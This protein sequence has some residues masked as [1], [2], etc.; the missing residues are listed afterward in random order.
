VKARILVVEDN[1]ANLQLMEYLLRSF[2]HEV[3]A[4]DN[5]IAGL[6]EAE[7]GGYDLV[8]SDVRMPHLDGYEFARRFKAEPRLHA[9]PLVA[10]TALAMA[11]D[12]RKA[13]D[14]GFDGYIIK[15]IDPERFVPAVESF[16]GKA[17]APAQSAQPLVLVIDDLQVNLDV[18]GGT[19]RPFGYR[20]VEAR[21]VNAAIERLHDERPAVIL[22]DLHMRGQDGFAMIEYVKRHPDL[23]TIPFIFVSSTAWQTSDKRRG[24]ELGAEKFLL[25]P[26][27]PQILLNE[28]RK[29]VERERDGQN[30]HP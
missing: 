4:I 20:V 18:V 28:V 12:R 25:R 10:V 16:V 26:I 2:G 17:K 24:L 13:L 21:S 22:C 19:L 15:P 1:A 3:K 6:E 27:D 29:V 8:L 7:R 14:A 9:T 11:G 30:S 5:A 23:K